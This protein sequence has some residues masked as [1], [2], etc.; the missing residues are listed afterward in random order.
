MSGG[1]SSGKASGAGRGEEGRVLPLFGRAL[2]VPISFLKRCMSFQLRA[3]V[4][5]A[6]TLLLE[7]MIAERK[8][9]LNAGMWRTA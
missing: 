4:I 5:S 9:G 3:R 2:L 6:K 1:S 8:I 7:D